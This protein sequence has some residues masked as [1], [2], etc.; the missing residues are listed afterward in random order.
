MLKLIIIIF[1]DLF[2]SHVE[3][4]YDAIYVRHFELEVTCTKS[5]QIAQTDGLV[6]LGIRFGTSLRKMVVVGKSNRIVV[7][8]SLKK[9][10]DLI[11]FDTIRLDK[12]VL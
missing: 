5:D 7:G 6:G 3:I 11:R 10:D 4:V 2:Q 1:T 8:T 9:M 12:N